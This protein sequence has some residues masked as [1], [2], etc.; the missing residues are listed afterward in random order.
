MNKVVLSV[1]VVVAIAIGGWY[2]FGGSKADESADSMNDQGNTMGLDEKEGEVFSGSLAELM[3]KGGDYRCTF[4]HNTSA[5]SSDGV[6]YMSGERIRGDFTSVVSALGI[7][8]ESHMISDG[9]NTYTWSPLTP[10]GYKAPV[11]KDTTEGDKSTQTEGSYSDINQKLDYHCDP[12]SV[13]EAVFA[14]PEGM[15]FV[16]IP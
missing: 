9:Q 5:G 13:D 11:V 15:S 8:V 6:V 14:L 4:N 2:M 16:D 12:W 7:T 3:E 1:V 10:Q